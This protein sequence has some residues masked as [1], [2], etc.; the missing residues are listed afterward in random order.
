M[1]TAAP[2]AFHLMAKPSGAICNLD[3]SY[4]YFLSKESLYPGSSFR[5]SEPTLESYVRQLIEAQR[6]PE[7]TFAW[8]GGEPTLMGIDFFERAFELQRRYRRPGM[9]IHNAMQT[10]GTRLDDAWGEFLAEHGVLVGI[11]LD[12]PRDLHDAYRVDKGGA[13]SFDRVMAGLGVLQRHDVAFNVLTT[14][15]RRNAP[16]PERVYR[17]LRDEVGARFL[18]FIPI[19]ERDNDTGFQEGEALTQRSVGARAYG[20][21]MN[22]IFDAWVR[23]DVGEVY[24][25][26]FDVTL[27]KYVG[28]RGGLCVFE[29]TCGDALA[30]EHNGDVYSCDHFVQPDHL[31]GNLQ[32][33]P[34]VDMV[35]SERQRAFGR[36]K[37]DTLPRQCLECE[38]RWLCHGGCP[39]DRVLRDAYGEPG[40]NAL[41]QGYLAFFRHTGPAFEFMAEEIR[42]GRPPAN[43]MAWLA[44]RASGAS[45]AGTPATER[46]AAVGPAHLPAG[47]GG[48]AGGSATP[49]R[50]D[51]CPCGSG[52]KFKHCCG[53]PS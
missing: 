27:G 6:V 13:G 49:G 32:E 12:G 45:T 39:K 10:N 4:C 37:R 22:A 47:A 51:P 15:H 48:A 7:V 41:C 1:T 36:A 20:R 53:R 9:T 38:V 2:P 19:V 29:E 5:M 25:Q 44:E 16:H 35:G 42:L 43:V 46:G 28:E 33:L 30:L 17:F 21:F 26:L 23:R 52:R 31:L 34:L 18:Q 24:V 40:L 3:C 11:S 14:V 50:N 8:Q